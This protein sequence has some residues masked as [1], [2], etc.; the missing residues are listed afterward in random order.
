MITLKCSNLFL[1]FALGFLSYI[2]LDALP[3]VSLIFAPFSLGLLGIEAFIK[4]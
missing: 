2:T 3:I 4:N 1:A